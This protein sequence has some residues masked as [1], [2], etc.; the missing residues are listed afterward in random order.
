LNK[1]L[2]IQLEMKALAVVQVALLS[3]YDMCKALDSG[4][5]MG[6]VKLLLESGA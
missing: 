1:I 2:D 6:E 4:M 3:I 5:V